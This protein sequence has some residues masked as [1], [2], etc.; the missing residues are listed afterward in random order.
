MQIINQ[1]HDF[2]EGCFKDRQQNEL[3]R[4]C[5]AWFRARS[6]AN[7]I[8]YNFL[9]KMVHHKTSYYENLRKDIEIARIFLL[10]EFGAFIKV[11]NVRG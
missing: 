2:G 3:Y 5:F 9:K 1:F 10:V 11:S 6:M 7:L 4:V 8:Q